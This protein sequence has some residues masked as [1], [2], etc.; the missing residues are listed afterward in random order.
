MGMEYPPLHGGNNPT[1]HQDTSSKSASRGSGTSRPK[2]RRQL[3]KELAR[4]AHERRAEAT[5]KY[6]NSPPKADDIWICEFCE[7]ERIFGEPPRA[8]IRAY[9]KKDRILRQE[10]AD[11]KRLLEKAKA[12]ARKGKRNAKAAAKANTSSNAA[13]G[14]NEQDAPPA[15]ELGEEEHEDD[16]EYKE[17]PPNLRTG[18]RPAT[19]HRAA[20][21]GSGAARRLTAG[22]S[23]GPPT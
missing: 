16:A 2:T 15:E 3:D 1:H 13:S 14:S 17:R 8:L 10:A 5:A 9:E 6:Y 22:S 12:K 19:E 20:G 7:Y 4:A 21:S 11:R 23:A 18:A